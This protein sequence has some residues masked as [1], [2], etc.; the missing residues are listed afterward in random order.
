MD[1]DEVRDMKRQLVYDLGDALHAALAKVA[2]A[3]APEPRD[4]HWCG[5]MLHPDDTTRLGW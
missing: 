4:P 1:A 3:P 5:E 2:A